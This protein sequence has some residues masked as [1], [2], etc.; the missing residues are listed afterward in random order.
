MASL[1]KTPD[2]PQPPAP[3]VMPIP[4]DLA[5]KQAKRKS[6]AERR[7]RGGRESTILSALGNETLG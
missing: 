4:D 1:F 2:I 6:I 7:R 3:P 5:Q